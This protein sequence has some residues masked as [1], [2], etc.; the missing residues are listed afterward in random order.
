MAGLRWS[1][2]DFLMPAMT[3]NGLTGRSVLVALVVVVALLAVGCG[4]H[5]SARQPYL[6]AIIGNDGAH[7]A[8]EREAGVDAKVV[9]LSWHDFYPAEGEVDTSYVE[10]KKEELRDLREAGFEVIVSLNFHDTPPWVHEN[11]PHSYYVNQ[12]GERWT[13]TNFSDGRL[14]DNGDANFVFNR[15]LRE[16]I[17]SYTEEVFSELGTDFWAVRLGGGRYGEVTY[18]PAE[19][20]GMG[21]LYWAYDENAQRSAAEAGVEGWRPGG[22]SPDGQAGRFLSWYLD[23]LVGFQNWQVSV[24]R[25]TGYSG[26]VM[27]LYG[28]RGIRPGEIEKATATNLGGSTPGEVNG[29]IQRGHDFARQVGA[30]EDHNVLVTTA[31]LDA[32]GSRDDD[33]DPS[34]WTPVKY[35]SYLTESNPANPGLYGE[36]T[37]AGSREDMWIAASQ[38]RRYGLLGMAWYNEEQLFSGRYANLAEYGRVIKTYQECG[39]RQTCPC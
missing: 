39:V 32:P 1:K 5:A 3:G 26:R 18:P 23:S 22:P 16:L 31:W 13:G 20:G 25:E 6:F 12:F 19:V 15:R 4:T 11:Y 35:L 36:N 24:V 7:L 10:Q 14:S 28:G 29:V 37:G 21:N 2:R 27:L 34:N 33:Q 30:I 9:R 8:Q 38:M 17:E